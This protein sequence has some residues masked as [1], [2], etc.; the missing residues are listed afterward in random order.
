[1]SR[2][3]AACHLRF[4]LTEPWPGGTGALET[5]PSVFN[6]AD[7]MGGKNSLSTPRRAEA[8]K[9]LKTEPRVAAVVVAA[10][11]PSRFTHF[12]SSRQRIYF[13]RMVGP[14][15]RLTF[16]SSI[17]CFFALASALSDRFAWIGSLAILQAKFPV[18]LSKQ[19]CFPEFFKRTEIHFPTVGRVFLE[20]QNAFAPEAW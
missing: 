20:E 7:A 8:T 15:R 12:P 13:S 14:R 1:M 6:L 16:P 9:R 3:A 11:A 4:K 19:K 10:E 5:L 18:G 17:L 2:P